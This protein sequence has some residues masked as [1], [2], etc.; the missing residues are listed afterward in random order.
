MVNYLSIKLR[1]EAVWLV[2][3][4]GCGI[5]KASLVWWLRWVENGCSLDARGCQ[6]VFTSV[7]EHRRRGEARRG[8]PMWKMGPSEAAKESLIVGEGDGDDHELLIDRSQ[9][10]CLELQM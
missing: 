8:G 4:V 1:G 6:A 3:A 10:S 9:Q 5:L 7:G 2:R